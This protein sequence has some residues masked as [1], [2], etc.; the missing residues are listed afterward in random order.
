AAPRTTATGTDGKRRARPG[1]APARA[2]PRT[3]TTASAAACRWPSRP[4]Q[5]QERARLDGHGLPRRVVPLTGLHR[6]LR[7][8]ELVRPVHAEAPGRQREFD[9]LVV[10]VEH[11]QE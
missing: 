2:P 7:R 10:R 6:R 9:R 5:Q 8:R 3:R 1:T 11:A 4:P